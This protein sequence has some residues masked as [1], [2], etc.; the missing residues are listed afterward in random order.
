MSQRRR[1]RGKGAKKYARSDEIAKPAA[2]ERYQHD[3]W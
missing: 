2:K 3:S 1:K